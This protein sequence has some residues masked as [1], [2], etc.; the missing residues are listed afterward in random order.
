[1]G[2][3]WFKPKA[4]GYGATPANWKGWTAAWAYSFVI[5]LVTFRLLVHPARKGGMVGQQVLLWVLAVGLLT[6]AFIWLV[7]KKTDGARK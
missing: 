1:M 2:D 7:R 5:T 4:N 3:H 6:A